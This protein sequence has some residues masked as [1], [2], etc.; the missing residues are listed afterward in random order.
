MHLRQLASGG[1]VTG[2]D[3]SEVRTAAV[4]SAVA[5]LVLNILDLVATDV[6][7]GQLGAIELNPLV[8]PMLG[9]PWVVLVKVGLPM[10][11]IALATRVSSWRAVGLIWSVIGIYVLVTLFN[12]GQIALVATNLLS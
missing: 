4:V 7:V 2:S 8:E 12:V 9:T 11:A 10:V 3:L 1:T 5:L 6:L